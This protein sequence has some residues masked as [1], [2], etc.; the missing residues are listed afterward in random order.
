MSD[1]FPIN[2]RVSSAGMLGVFALSWLFPLWPY[3]QAL[4]TS[5]ALIGFALLWRYTTRWQLSDRDFFFIAAFFSIHSIAGR[6]LYSYVPYDQWTQWAF[7]FSLSE[8]MGWTRNHF[9]RLVHFMFGI[10]FTPAIAGV[11]ARRARLQPVH[12]FL[13]AV[14]AVMVVSLWYEWFEWLIA[15]TMSGKDAEAYNGQQGDGWDAHKDMLLA[16]VGSLCWLLH[17]RRVSRRALQGSV[18]QSFT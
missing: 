1:T 16:T 17:Y 4:H 13:A 2:K 8:Q 15:M 14:T 7:G 3:E 5:L 9:D 11:A 12:A 10:C 6:W 18:I